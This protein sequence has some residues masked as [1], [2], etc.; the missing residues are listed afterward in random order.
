MKKGRT[1]FLFACCLLA[2]SLLT[3]MRAMPDLSC[4]SACVVEIATNRVLYAEECEKRLPMAS[5][6]K[7]MT[8]LLTIENGGLDKVVTV[9]GQ[10]VGVEGSSL[11][12]KEGEQFTR[13]DLLYA[14]MLVSGNDCSGDTGAG[15]G[16]QRGRVLPP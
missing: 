4:Q 7:I 5:T 9:P 1:L 14:L 2:L 15:C 11:Y 10:A 6:T 8:A 12:L 13:R 16:G 3:G